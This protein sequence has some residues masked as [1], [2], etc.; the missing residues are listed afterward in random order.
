MS[1][2]VHPLFDFFVTTSGQSL[3]VVTFGAVIP[4]TVMDV[5]DNNIACI[6]NIENA[7]GLAHFSRHTGVHVAGVNLGILINRAQE[8]SYFEYSAQLRRDME[9]ALDQLR[10]ETKAAV[11]L[12]LEQ[13]HEF[14][15]DQ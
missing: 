7:A 4:V 15:V 2:N 8:G 13:W 10:E 6:L 3:T 9:Q 1:R 12:Q 5:T 14:P 11:A